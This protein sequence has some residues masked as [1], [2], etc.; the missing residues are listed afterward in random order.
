[1][2]V[3][4]LNLERAPERR[5]AMLSQVREHA[6]D[7]EILSAVDG[8]KI[9]RASLPPGTRASL[10]S[11]EVGCYLS[12]LCAWQTVVSR[13]LDHAIILEDDVIISPALKRAVEEIAALELPF[14]AVR[15]SAL[16][17]VR[18]IPVASLSGGVQLVLPTKNPSGA[19]G[20][21]VSQAGAKR[22]LVQLAVPQ[23]PVDDAFDDYWKHG[24]CIP[25]LHPSL[26]EEDSALS[27]TI[28][29][30]ADSHP[31]KTLLRHLTRVVE[32]QRRKLAVSL[33]ARRL[34]AR[35]MIGA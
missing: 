35:A 4:V 12:H 28:G 18:G 14:D 20:Y 1:M 25:V 2:K 22:L 10:S 6:L 7:A 19:Q 31:P 34:R 8:A 5:R 3:F 15:L 21:L 33:M 26:V 17:P 27:S 24:L 11:G 9:D 16:R 30:R 29:H 13:G 23:K 32:A